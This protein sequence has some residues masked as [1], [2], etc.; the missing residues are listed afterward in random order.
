MTAASI[1]ETISIDTQVF[2]ATGYGFTGKSFQSL[3]KHLASGRLRLVMTDITVREVHARIEQSVAEALLRHREFVKKA[4]ALFNSSIPA[5]KAS[6]TKFDPKVVAK[7]LCDQFDS[8]LTDVKAEIV[9]T[10]D[11]TI[12]DVLDKYF[13]GVA[14]FGS[15]ETK[16]HEFPDA[17]CLKALSEW[18]LQKGVKMFVVSG[19]NDFF[20]GCCKCTQLI[21]RKTLNEVLDHV[22][23]DESARAGFVRRETKKRVSEIAEEAKHQFQDRYY[24]VEN[25][26]GDAE[27]KVETISP[28][29]DPEIVEI[30]KEQASLVVTFE[31]RYSAHLSYDD[32]ATASYDEGDLVYVE[33][34]EEDV[35]DREQLLTLEVKVTFDEFDPHSFEITEIDLIEPGDS[36]AIETEDDYGWPYK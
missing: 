17:F 26:D 29:Q 23:S 33:H 25:M 9:A 14:P 31:A 22:A 18:A 5:V 15:T 8:F 27:V 11:L 4:S 13:A 21:S 35:L 34:R 30:G 36:F 7:D 3:K 24:W 20:E 6:V 2:V 10:R 16:K 28:T 1:V 19:D 32:P 12:G